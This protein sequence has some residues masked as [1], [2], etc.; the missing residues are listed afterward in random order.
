LGDV[1]DAEDAFQAVFLVLAR[2]AVAVHPPEALAAWP[3]WGRTPCGAQGTISPG[4]P[5]K[6]VWPT[7]P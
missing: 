5:H 4:P 1:H 7:H 3:A 2:K 6:S